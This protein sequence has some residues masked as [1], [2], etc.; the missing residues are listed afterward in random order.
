MYSSAGVCGL[1]RDTICH[2]ECHPSAAVLW[3]AMRLIIN[4]ANINCDCNYF[5]IQT[6][7][8]Y[9]Y[10]YRTRAVPQ[11]QEK[12]IAILFIKSTSI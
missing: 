1:T 2:R 3:S 8:S 12:S 4:D 6:P 10:Y 11:V 7:P 9:G 5:G